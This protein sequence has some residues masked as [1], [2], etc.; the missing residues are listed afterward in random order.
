MEKL[1]NLNAYHYELPKELIAQ[2]P[3]QKRDSSR[4]MIIHREQQ[5]FEEIV[6]RD[7]PDFLKKGDSLIFNN[8]KVIPC[9]LIGKRK[10]GGET[11]V[12]LLKKIDEFTWEALVRPG[13]KLP[14]GATIYFGENLSATIQNVDA[15]GIRVVKF[16]YQGSWDDV[17][18]KYGKI[19]LPQ[20]IEREVEK[21]LDLDRY[22]TIYAQHPGSSAAPTAGLHFSADLLDKLEKQGV[23]Q[24]KIT[25]HVGL[26]TFKPVKTHD[27][28]E[29]KMH[30]EP[31]MISE[32]EAAKLNDRPPGFKQIVV[33]TTCCRAL[34]SSADG[35]GIIKPGE[36]ETNIFIYPGYRFKYV[37]HLL[38]NFH[39]PGSTLL[40]LVCAFGG[41]EL[42]MEAYRKAVLDKYRF[43]SY[44]DAMLIL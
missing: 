24:S 15:E 18:E 17:L 31:F 2:Y 3:A 16:D 19:P 22:Q 42:M 12:F 26:G 41:Y 5:S 33:G 11:E 20:Y 43:F 29:H 7:L 34:E 30:T 40:M 38:T 1:F 13:R 14:V 9:R 39:L 23:G 37:R 35:D 8:T 32:K 36:Y 10:G 21:T 27:I 25:L 4:L 6:F 28:R 44:G